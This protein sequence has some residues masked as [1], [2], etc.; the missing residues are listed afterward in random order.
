[1]RDFRLAA[2]TRVKDKAKA[3]LS[4]CLAA[5]QYASLA[6]ASGGSDAA[7]EVLT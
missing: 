7:A 1:M 2:T 6:A 5:L 4:A 3:V